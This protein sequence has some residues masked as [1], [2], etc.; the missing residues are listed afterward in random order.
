MLT[1]SYNET[2]EF[3]QHNEFETVDECMKDAK[4]NYGMKVGE[5]IAIG[6]VF[7][8]QVC[9][10]AE[11]LLE[12]IEEEAYEECGEVAEDWGITS[13][14]H[15]DKEIDELQDKVTMLVIEYLEKIGEKPTF[16]KIDNIYTVTLN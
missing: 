13:R 1:W 3:W 5:D 11:S 16:S 12:R 9:V 14:E 10:D 2:D 4:E 8:Y 6:T 15:F 7:P